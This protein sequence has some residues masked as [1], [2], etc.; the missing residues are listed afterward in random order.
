MNCL[1]K[2]K[3]KAFL[4]QSVAGFGAL[5]FDASSRLDCCMP[6]S[7]RLRSIEV[8]FFDDLTIAESDAVVGLLHVKISNATNPV[9]LPSSSSPLI[10]QPGS[11][12]SAESAERL[13]SSNEPI[14]EATI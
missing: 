5:L 8:F 10:S 11:G 9:T 7:T 6:I 13:E 1:Q 2:R 3:E 4:P 14:A 12:V